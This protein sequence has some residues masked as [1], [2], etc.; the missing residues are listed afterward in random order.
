MIMVMYKYLWLVEIYIK[1]DERM[2]TMYI[3]Y[4]Y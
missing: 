2:K 4:C 1:I 3:R